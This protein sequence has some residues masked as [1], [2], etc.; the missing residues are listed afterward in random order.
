MNKA[1]FNLP[2]II[3]AV[4]SL[5]ATGAI[6]WAF[7]RKPEPPTLM[8]EMLMPVPDFTVTDHNGK[9]ITKQDMLGRVWVCDFFLT[10]CNGVCPILGLK[11]ADL[12][13]E[14]GKRDEYDEVRLI[15]FS[16][17]PEYDTLERLKQYRTINQT[18]WAQ[19]DKHKQAQIDQRW[20]H[21]RADDQEAFWQLVLDGF[22][23][24]V[25]S[26]D[27]SDQSTPVAHSR[28]FV[29][30][31]R[32]GMIRGMYDAY[33]QEEMDTILADIRRLVNEPK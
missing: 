18:V 6:S 8:S 17:D 29:L 14:L 12:A 32:S 20:V 4:L 15:S 30:I 5:A 10:R 22:K 27:P 7:L 24:H 19:G 33:S 9:T 3:T 31:D 11:M 26:A 16:V 21:A 2:V 23:L 1:L 28:R 13:E 25:G